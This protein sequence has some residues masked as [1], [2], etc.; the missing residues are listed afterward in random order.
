MGKLGLR[1]LASFSIRPK[2]FNYSR[3]S[4]LNIMELIATLLLFAGALLTV[5]SEGECPVAHTP[6]CYCSS[7][8]MNINCDATQS[9]TN[10]AQTT[11]TECE[12]YCTS[13]C[14]EGSG[15]SFSCHMNGLESNCGGG[16]THC[17]C[18]CEH[19]VT[20]PSPILFQGQCVAFCQR[21]DVCNATGMAFTCSGSSSTTTHSSSKVAV[22]TTTL[23]T[24]TSFGFLAG[25]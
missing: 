18:F 7:N 23:V 16:I 11:A 15:S 13:E 2:A 25:L 24:V 19:N 6:R 21:E 9:I 14:G 17:D 3:S 20:V 5:R 1:T 8:A 10:T 22:L 4:V 12:T